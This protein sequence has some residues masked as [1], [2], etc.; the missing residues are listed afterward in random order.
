LYPL[1]KCVERESKKFSAPAEL[2]F[3]IIW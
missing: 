1:L 3:G 2:R